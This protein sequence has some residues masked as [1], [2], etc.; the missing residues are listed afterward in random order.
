MK[1]EMFERIV[2]LGDKSTFFDTKGKTAL[3]LDEA[4]NLLLSLGCS[5][6]STADLML[7][8]FQDRPVKSQSFLKQ[9]QSTQATIDEVYEKVKPVL[10]L[11]KFSTNKASFL[12]TVDDFSEVRFAGQM[13]ADR[14]EE[15]IVLNNKAMNIIET[16][17]KERPELRAQ[18][19]NALVYG[20][21]SRFK[22][23]RDLLFRSEPPLL[24]WGAGPAFKVIE[25]DDFEQGEHTAWDEFLTRVNYPETFKAYVWS[26]FD[27]TNFGRQA[28]WI[29]GEGNDGKSTAINT[30]IRFYGSDYTLSMGHKTVDESFFFGQAYGKRLAVYMDCKNLQILQKERIKSLLGRDNVAI[31]DKHDK[32]FTGQ[33]YSK[34]FIGSNSYPQISFADQSERT[35]LLLLRVRTYGDEAGDPDFEDRLYEEMPAFLHSCKEAYER[36]CPRG[37]SLRVPKTMAEEILLNCI[38]S[39]SELIEAFIE[40]ELEFDKEFSTSDKKLRYAFGQFL[41]TNYGNKQNLTYQFDELKKHLE[42]QGCVIARPGTDGKRQRVRIGVRVKFK[43][44]GK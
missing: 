12:Y 10:G 35:R 7:R 3:S 26:L 33:V 39:D 22:L 20:L 43:E 6:V 23:D 5:N 31:N 40:E 2:Y 15:L 44:V 17:Y 36:E 18:P 11:S 14:F 19:M 21:F 27:P 28:L 25:P 42:K 30:L 41:A 13:K 4:R 38:S 16:E 24:A 1:K 9:G 37:M 34:L 8:N 32:I 29:Y